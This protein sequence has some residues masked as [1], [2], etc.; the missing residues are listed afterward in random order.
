MT[1]HTGDSITIGDYIYEYIENTGQYADWGLHA[2][3]VDT[4]K[5]SYGAIQNP[6]TLNGSTLYVRVMSS[7]FSMCENMTSAPEIPS[8]VELLDN[9]FEW[10][11]S[12]ETAPV[13]PASATS[14]GG[15]FSN[16]ENLRGKVVI[17]SST[18]SEYNWMFNGIEHHIVLYGTSTQLQDIVDES[19]SRIAEYIHYPWELS[20]SISASRQ[21]TDM[22]TVNIYIYATSNY[23]SYTDHHMVRQTKLYKDGNQISATFRPINGYSNIWPYFDEDNYEVTL[24][25]EIPIG[26]SASSF[27]AEVYDEYGSVRTSTVTVPEYILPSVDFDVYRTNNS[28]TKDDEGTYG[29]IQATISY[30]SAIANLVAPTVKTGSTDISSNVTW[31]TTTPPYGVSSTSISD[32]STVVYSGQTP[33]TVYGLINGSFSQASSYQITLIAEDNKGGQSTPITQTLSTAYYTIDFLAGGKEIAFGLPANDSLTTN[34]QNVG[35]FKCGMEA[36]FNEEV[37]FNED[38]TIAQDLAASN[39]VATQNITTPQIIVTGLVGEIKMWAGKTVPNGWL[40]C[41]GDVQL[42]SDYPLLAKVLELSWGTPTI[43][44]SSDTTVNLNKFYF[45]KINGYYIFIQNPTGSPVAEGWYESSTFYLPNLNGKVPV[46][47]DTSDVDFSNVGGSGGSKYVQAHTHAVSTQPAFTIPNHT[48]TGY[49][50]KDNSTGGGA[51]RIGHSGAYA[52][53]GIVITP[54]SGGGGA[55]TRTTNVA[56]GAVSGATTGSSGNLQPYAVVKYIICAA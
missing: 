54:S 11:T 2:R 4:T 45:E 3:V 7:C 33:P 6:V 35:L 19:P 37:V 42:I 28:G 9:C 43:V 1:A 51:D 15:M 21:L 22:M 32:W 50:R 34:Q 14:V 25:A 23:G 5:T 29:L 31:Y 38:V 26:S 8:T 40:E 46:G 27:Y 52:A 30:T 47:Q 13:I 10:C 56:I 53:S 39:F 16:C 48:H 55:C 41:N 36:K 20:A 49:Y 44:D 12:L 18:L 24:K 17:N